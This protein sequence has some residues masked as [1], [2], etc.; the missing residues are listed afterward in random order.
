MKTWCPPA[1]LLLLSACSA[2]APAPETTAQPSPETAPAKSRPAPQTPATQKADAPPAGDSAA[3]DARIDRVLGSHA[4]YRSVFERLQEAVASHDP[5]GVAAMVRYP[6][7]IHTEAGIEQVDNAQTFVARY[8]DIMRPSIV[9][10]IADARYGELFVSQNGVMLGAGQ[11][12]I[13]GI[14]RD[15][16]CVD[17]DVKVTALQPGG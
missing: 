8:E 10:A 11:V 14:C 4:A 9:Q 3:M 12:W 5:M 17:V 2:Q 6:L 7:K 15:P 1:L 16:A 13:N